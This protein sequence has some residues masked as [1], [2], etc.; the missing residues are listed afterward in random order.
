[1]GD[2]VR[3]I[4]VEEAANRL[5]KSVAT[6]RRALAAGEISGQKIG[7]RWIVHGDKL[8]TATA[9]VSSVG[10]T[11][12]IDLE[13]SM[14]HVLRL[15]RRELWV[16]DVLNW[17]DFRARPHD[18]IASARLKCSTGHA[19]PIEVVEV[20]KGELLSRAGTLLTL[21]DRVAYHA[22]CASFSGPIEAATSDHVFSSRINDDAKGDFFRSGYPQWKAFIEAVHSEVPLVGSWI[23]HTDLVSYFETISHQLLFDDL[24]SLGVADGVLTPLRLLLSDWRQSSKHGLPIG[25]D[26]SRLLGNFFMSRIDHAMLD[27]GLSYWRYMDDIRIVAP[28]E[29]SALAAL[30]TFEVACR[31]RGLVV[32]GAKTKIEEVDPSGP[33]SEIDH[34]L[35]A[36]DYFFRN[37]LSETR[38][39]L[40]DLFRSALSEKEIKRKHAKFALLR[41]GTL[42]DRGILSRLLR[43]LDKLKEVSPDSA[44]YL[45][46]FISEPSVKKALTSYLAEP[47]NPGVEVYQQAW[48]IG[49]MLEVLNDVPAEWVSYARIVA[50]D[51]NQPTFLR[52]LALNLT[53]LGRV[54]AD[55]DVIREVARKS[56]DPALV[57]G[58]LV[59][60]RR[61]DLLDKQ[62]QSLVL[63]RLPQLKCTIE[64][65]LPRVSL[66]SLVQEGLWGK[67][68]A[69]PNT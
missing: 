35:D 53:A 54:P 24:R 27:H 17:E 23:V 6:V 15:D 2:S 3:N 13:L 47:G 22:L 56:Y 67:L 37:G 64:Y 10:D 65:L 16:P 45:R 26:A 63:A 30:R 18:V 39:S 48:L 33:P 12:G 41:L 19:D 55:L 8:P 46:A 20:P 62:T 40:R 11:A 52:A 58:A 4:T 61:I 5:G 42:V 51:G 21:A 14:R 69:L 50:F 29:R 25:M 44:F 1:M 43:R 36:A 31:R 7:S 32:S 59:A 28:S 49:A 68:R 60:L 66:P 57:R 38:K 34:R 9:G